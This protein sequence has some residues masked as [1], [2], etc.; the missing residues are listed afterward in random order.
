MKAK[1]GKL[2]LSDTEFKNYLLENYIDENGDKVSDRELWSRNDFFEKTGLFKINKFTNKKE[3]C[4][5][6]TISYWK[7]KLL[8]KEQSVFEYHQLITK[9]ISEN[10]EFEVWSKKNNKGHNKITTLTE[11]TVKRRMIKHFGLLDVY[12]HLTLN[13]VHNAIYE[14][15]HGLGKDAKEEIAKFYNSMQVGE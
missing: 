13:Q 12:N 14:L 5:T 1:N 6:G 3:I 8:L 10:T 2:K 9:K 7:K 15:L 11:E 4:S